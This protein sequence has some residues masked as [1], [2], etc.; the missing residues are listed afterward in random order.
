VDSIEALQAAVAVSPDDTAIRALLAD[1]LLTA[2]RVED[3]I[4]Q[5]RQL[6]RLAPGNAMHRIRLADAYLRAGKPQVAREVLIELP[7]VADADPVALELHAD[8]Q[9]RLSELSDSGFTPTEE[10]VPT[11]PT[12]RS[13]SFA[14]VGGMESLKEEVRLKVIYPATRPEVY[15]AYGQASGGAILLYGPPGCGKTHLARATAGEIGA[16]FMSVGIT[17]VLSK[18]IGESEERL[19]KIF[20]EA[21][22]RS[23]TVLFFD[24]VDA[25]AA[26]RG[27][28]VGGAGRNVTNQ[29]LAELDGVQGA[30]VGV[31]TLAATNAPWHVDSAFRRPGRFGQAIFVPPPDRA[32]RVAILR[33]LVAA[34]PND[35]IDFERVAMVTDRFS[36]ADLKGIVD[37]AV[38]AN[39]AQTLRDGSLHPVTTADLLSRASS[40]APST[41]EWFANVRNYVLFANQ[42]GL[43]DAVRPYL[44]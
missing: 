1:R 8:V 29:F 17:D 18:W 14:D 2:D 24:E 41:N 7:E 28:F 42:G 35:A 5:Y 9:R 25:L 37:A 31:L 26:D 20:E 10:R 30:N 39:L 6:V 19:H 32:A 16:H 38:Q 22:R 12:G 13:V 43:Y 40:V 11:D 33:V 23:P 15:A 3:A 44:K 21:R 34:V 36:G 27:S 4:D